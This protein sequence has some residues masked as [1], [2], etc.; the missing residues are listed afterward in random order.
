MADGLSLLAGSLRVLWPNVFTFVNAST[1]KS[2]TSAHPLAVKQEI[3]SVTKA[4]DRLSPSLVELKPVGR[5]TSNHFRVTFI[6]RSL[7]ANSTCWASLSGQTMSALLRTSQSEGGLATEAPRASDGSGANF[8]CFQLQ[9][10]FRSS[11]G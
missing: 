9:E 3:L 4:G 1:S 11:E 8:P 2:P 6:F 10:S 7:L 5:S